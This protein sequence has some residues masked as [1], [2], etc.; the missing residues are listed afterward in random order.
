VR[1]ATLVFLTN[2]VVFGQTLSL[3][4]LGGVPVTSAFRSVTFPE[5]AIPG[6][7]QFTTRSSETHWTAGPVL[8]IGLRSHLEVEAGALRRNFSL[9]LHKTGQYSYAYSRS[10]GRVWQF[11]F[12]LRYRL[13]TGGNGPTAGVGASF[14]KFSGSNAEHWGLSSGGGAGSVAA[15]GYSRR[16][17]FLSIEPQL[18]YTHWWNGNVVNNGRRYSTMNQVE[19][20]V[21]VTADWWRRGRPKP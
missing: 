20:L 15:L 19:I 14:R 21:S 5:P 13:N 6:A 8:R 2:G 9:K 1:I 10:D 18:R 12:L 4:V 16:L 7:Y 11:P 3:G 17:A